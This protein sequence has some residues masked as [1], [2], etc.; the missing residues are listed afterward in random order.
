MTQTHICDV[1]IARDLQVCLEQG[2]TEQCL[3]ILDD[4]KSLP[5]SASL[6]E[7]LKSR[8]TG[9]I[10]ISHSSHPPESL[11]QEIDQQLIRGW[12]PIS[13]Q[14][15]STVHTTQRIV[16]SVMSLTHFTPLN[17]EQKLLEK[18]ASLTSGCPGLVTITNS[19]LHCCLEE[20]GRNT[21]STQ[22]D[23]LHVFASKV[24]VNLDR[25]TRTDAP[26]SSEL[27]AARAR[28]GS[29]R[30][31]RYLSELISAFQLPPA[32]LFVLRTLSVFSPQPVPLSLVDIVQC[33]VAKA[34]VSSAGH[35]RVAPSSITN[36]LSTK[37]LRSYPSPVICP[38]TNPPPPS[39]TTSQLPGKYLFVPQLV[40]DT[41]WEHMDD[42]DIVFTI[43]TAYRA[44]LEMTSRPSITAS[45]VCF[46]TGLT[47]CLVARCDS[48]SCI[49]EGVYREI[50]KMFVD[51][52]LRSGAT[53]Q[54]NAPV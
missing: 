13:I 2:F 35:S 23:F 18:I 19:L 17:R 42:R 45:G 7:L 9:I 47:E 50:F 20:A 52:Q 6:R 10:I 41:L 31:N 36:L 14:P 16:H 21:G 12:T 5:Q 43:T 26:S 49:S 54:S 3:V 38:P 27:P 11:K 1:I 48:N 15:L 37:L 22:A 46:A 4:V 30:T 32:H 8:S 28:A 29:F 53:S 34:A 24:N 44:L 51:L 33:L 40:Q 39:P 25:S